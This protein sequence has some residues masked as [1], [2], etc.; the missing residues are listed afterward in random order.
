MLV[1]RYLL[2]SDFH[3]FRSYRLFFRDKREKS[4]CANPGL[5]DDS[6]NIAVFGGVFLHIFFPF[7]QTSS[8]V[9]MSKS[10]FTYTKERSIFQST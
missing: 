10:L 1:Y 5:K 7:S 8:I 6:T 9:L 4:I 3:K 2:I